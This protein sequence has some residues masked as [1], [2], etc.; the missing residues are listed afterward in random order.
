[1]VELSAVIIHLA[2]KDTHHH[3][4]LRSLVVAM[5]IQVNGNLFDVWAN[6]WVHLC[7]RA[8]DHLNPLKYVMVVNNFLPKQAL[9]QNF[10]LKNIENNEKLYLQ[11]Y[12]NFPQRIY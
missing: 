1:M 10:I 8:N 12:T 11:H 4:L 7:E 2:N 6:R 9:E 3:L 5:V